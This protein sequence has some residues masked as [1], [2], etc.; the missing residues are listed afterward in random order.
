MRL[1]LPPVT[2]CCIGLI[3]LLG[4]G[5]ATA[6]QNDPRLDGLFAELKTSADPEG[7]H[8]IERMIWQVWLDSGDA[9]VNRLMD[10][11]VAAMN[12]RDLDGAVE[13][14]DRIIE[15]KPDFAEGWNKRATVYY[16]QDKL[17]ASVRDVQRTLALEPRHF[18]ALSG[19]GL[20]FTEV[21]N[22]SAAI[23][24]YEAVL[25]LHPQSVGAR[26]NLEQL[27]ARLRKNLI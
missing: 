3:L 5:S 13:I 1:V 24:A 16:M 7:A 8:R 27:R 26:I 9:E 22:F 10:R 6:D 23:E 18:G 11:G 21:G 2:A 14:F 20:I 19:M 4:L 12:R 17:E 25:D 15:Q